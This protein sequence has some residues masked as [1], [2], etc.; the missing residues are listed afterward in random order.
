MAK[1]KKHVTSR[2]NR[3]AEQRLIT[4]EKIYE[5]AVKISNDGGKGYT[6][7]GAMKRW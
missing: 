5:N 1:T 3:R 6:R 7:P 2:P 4:A